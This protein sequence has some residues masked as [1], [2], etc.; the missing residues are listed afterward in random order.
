[1]D[2]GSAVL[3]NGIPLVVYA[4]YSI[5]QYMNIDPDQVFPALANTTRL[6]CLYLVA[7]NDDV[8]VCE[9]VEALGITQPR[10]SKALNA[11]KGVGLLSVHRDANWNYFSLDNAMPEWTAALIAAT[12]NGLGS[13]RTHVTDQKRFKR[14]NLRGTGAACS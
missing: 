1:V 3:H 14:L 12:V 8:C 10:A 4:I 5:F 11:L 7:S 9:V 6:R 13:S 2:K